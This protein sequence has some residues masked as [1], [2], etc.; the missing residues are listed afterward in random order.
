MLH[1]SNMKICLPSYILI[2]CS[3]TFWA[4]YFTNQ[5]FTYF[6]KTLSFHFNM[7]LRDLYYNGLQNTH[8]TMKSLITYI[9][10]EKDALLALIK[11]TFEKTW[12]RKLFRFSINIILKGR[13]TS[14]PV[15]VKFF[16]ENTHRRKFKRAISKTKHGGFCD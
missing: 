7:P 11:F 15:Y 5:F 6:A 2:A 16:G 10:D 3:N 9:C 8:F 14:K 13:K 1:C 12:Q 4:H